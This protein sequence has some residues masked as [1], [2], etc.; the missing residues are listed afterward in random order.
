MVVIS[1]L[2]TLLFCAWPAAGEAITPDQLLI[3]ANRLVP[4]SVR[5]A[6]YYMKKRNVPPENIVQIET[7]RKE[8]IGREQFERE[9]ASPVR[10][11]LTKNDPEGKR[12]K[13]IV[14]VYG[15]PLRVD[16]P[17]LT[18]QEQT[19]VLELRKRLAELQEKM[20]TSDGSDPQPAKTMKDEIAR[21]EK[22]IQQ[23]S[24]A[25]Q[26]ASVDSEIALVMEKEYPLDGWL[27]NRYSVAFRGK[28]IRNMPQRVIWVSRLDGP[29]EATV[30]RVIDDSVQVEKSGL[31]GKA[32]FDARWPDKGD[33][34]LSPYQFYDRAIHEAAHI[35]EKSGK[36]PVV[37]DEQERLFQPGEAPDAALYCGWYSLGTYVDAFTWAKGAVG[38]H[39]ASAEC[40]T[41]KTKTSTV[42]C[43]VMLEK[44][45]AATLGPVSEPYV[46][47][48]PL[49]HVFF[50]CLLDGNSLVE[51]YAVSNPFWSWQMV[52]IGDPLYRPFKSR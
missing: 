28:E 43:K 26:R 20:K 40:S 2:A 45:V 41:L 39:I 5:L 48:F 22:E 44:G 25:L 29:S 3:V 49:P 15:I 8:Q 12:F 31:A 32:Y 16:P 47:A 38:F 18:T 52:L 23:A 13:C 42:W 30:Y 19:R 4:E 50:G 36:L 35:V 33:Q 34:N 9:V 46:Q 51:C 7:S 17:R 11:F 10:G 37:L 21:T 14:L 24:K 6:Q 1:A 27:P